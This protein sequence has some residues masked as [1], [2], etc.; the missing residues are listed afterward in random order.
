[1]NRNE[2]TETSFNKAPINRVFISMG[3]VVITAIMLFTGLLPVR[4]ELDLMRL[5]KQLDNIGLSTLSGYFTEE[6]GAAKANRDVN[7]AENKGSQM[8]VSA[9]N[10]AGD[11]MTEHHDTVTLVIPPKQ[12]L[13]YRLAM[14]RDYD[15]EYSWNTDGKPVYAE[16]RGEHTDAKNSNSKLFAKTASNKAHG[17]FIVPFTGHFGWHWDNKTGLAITVRLTT[18]GVYEVM[19]FGGRPVSV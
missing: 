1:M 3:L 18:K 2:K 13:S 4:L 17:Y 15:L 7:V 9:D 5:A 12:Q 6:K 8:V 19:E 11:I 16:F 10:H 14:E